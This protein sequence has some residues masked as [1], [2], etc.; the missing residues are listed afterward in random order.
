MPGS[1][2][3]HRER[4]E[5]LIQSATSA[6]K[7]ATY[8]AAFADLLWRTGEPKQARARYEAARSIAVKIVDPAR[9]KQVLATIDQGLQYVSDPPPDLVSAI[10]HPRP[11]FSVR[12]ST[13]PAFPITTDGFQDFDPEEKAAHTQADEEMMKRLYERA[14]AGDLA[15]IKRITE[16]AAAPFQRAFAIASLEHVLIQQRQPQLAEEYAKKIPET[17]SAS[18][19][20]KAEAMSAAAAAWLRA[21]NDERGRADFDLAKGIVF[22]V[23]DLPF[24]RISVLVSIPEAQSK[25]GMIKEGQGTFRSAIELAQR[26]PLR[27]HPLP[28]VRR[29]PTPKR[30]ALQG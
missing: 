13:I 16:S 11:R 12:D 1:F 4:A 29:P 18:A 6:E 17:D 27:P 30:C 3:G 7:K 23:R 22:S 5:K 25:Y 9:R 15:G 14:A 19:L 2:T 21:L 26:L 8:F 28:G 24:G 20:A 10:P